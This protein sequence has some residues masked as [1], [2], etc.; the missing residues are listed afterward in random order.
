[1]LTIKIQYLHEDAQQPKR[2]TLGPAGWDVYATVDGAV[3]GG[4]RKRIPLGFA[5]EL[6]SGWCARLVQRSSMFE[7]GILVNSSPIDL[8]YRGELHAIVANNGEW[9]WHY[10]KGDRIAQLVFEHVPVVRFAA[11]DEL[12][13]TERGTGGFGSSGL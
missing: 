9:P 7:K 5:I 2:A 13:V 11:V 1:M 6:P 3:S 4:R 10:K 12:S 8:D